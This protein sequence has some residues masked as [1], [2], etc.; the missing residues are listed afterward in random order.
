MLAETFRQL[1][2][3]LALSFVEPV[4]S[5]NFQKPHSIN[6]LSYQIGRIVSFDTFHPSK[7]PVVKCFII[8]QNQTL[9]NDIVS[10]LFTVID[11]WLLLHF[12]L[13]KIRTKL[14]YR[15]NYNLEAQHWSRTSL[16]M[17]GRQLWANAVICHLRS[18]SCP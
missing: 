3:K 15:T 1:W 8:W 7:S 11:Q 14:H 13:L 17:D 5:H 2:V 4:W 10:R 16:F 9:L 6:L 18:P 12:W